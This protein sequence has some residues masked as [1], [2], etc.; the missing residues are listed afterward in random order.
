MKNLSLIPSKQNALP[1]KLEEKHSKRIIK[2]VQRGLS[3]P[4]KDLKDKDVELACHIQDLARDHGAREKIDDAVL[5]SCMNLVNRRY[6][7]FGLNE[8][9]EA[10]ELAEIGKLGKMDMT[11]YGGVFNKG[12]LSRVLAAYQN[13]RN[14]IVQDINNEDKMKLYNEEEQAKREQFDKTFPQKIERAKTKYASWHRVPK[15]WL[16]PALRL[17][18]MGLVKEEEE[19]FHREAVHLTRLSLKKQLKNEVQESARKEIRKE[20]HDLDR[21]VRITELLSTYRRLVVFVK[22]LNID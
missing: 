21:G 10:F 1:S 9:K 18:L 12:I 20:L 19:L 14:K 11:T 5:K 22:L 3:C 2:V 6:S 17:N 16:K 13:Y 8:L 4:I 7:S 15:F